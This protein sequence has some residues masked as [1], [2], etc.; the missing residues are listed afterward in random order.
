MEPVADIE[1][2]TRFLF[3]GREDGAYF[4]TNGNNQIDKHTASIKR[5]ISLFLSLVCSF[6]F[7]MY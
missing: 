6:Y 3:Y 7:E 5:Y 4:A 1:L 2:V